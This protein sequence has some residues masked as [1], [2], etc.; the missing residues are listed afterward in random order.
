LEYQP[1]SN[2][3][4]TVVL[5]NTMGSILQRKTVSGGTSLVELQFDVVAEKRGVYFIR[6]IDGRT[7]L[8]SKFVKK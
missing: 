7:T 3:D 8:N 2:E 6:I 5:Y 4:V 1:L